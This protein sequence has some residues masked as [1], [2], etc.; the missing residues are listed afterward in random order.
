MLESCEKRSWK[1][2]FA[3]DDSKRGRA[4]RK[5]AISACEM[6]EQKAI[7]RH[8]IDGNTGNNERGNL[9]F[10]CRKWLQIYY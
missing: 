1:G 5:Y 6:C 9:L 4:R 3:N 8:H 2:D 10:L 7:D